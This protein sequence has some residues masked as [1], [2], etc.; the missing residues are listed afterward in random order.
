MECIR[1]QDR[2]VAVIEQCVIDEERSALWGLG[3]ILAGMGLIMIW[4]LQP[5]KELWPGDVR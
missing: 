3:A 2:E 5:T 1:R 4:A